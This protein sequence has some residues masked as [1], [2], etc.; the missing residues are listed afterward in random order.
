MLKLTAIV[1]VA[2]TYRLTALI[3]RIIVKAITTMN[4]KQ[5]MRLGIVVME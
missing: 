4:V 3:A 1:V 2:E 5:M